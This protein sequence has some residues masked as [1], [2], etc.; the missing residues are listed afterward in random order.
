[1]KKK[2]HG[3]HFLYDNAVIAAVKQRVTCD[4]ADFYGRDMQALVHR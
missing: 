1:M 3:Q 2:L 4:G